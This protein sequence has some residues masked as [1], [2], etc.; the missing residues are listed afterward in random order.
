VGGDET[1]LRSS[2]PVP[3]E[4]AEPATGQERTAEPGEP[5]A[6]AAPPLAGRRAQRGGRR[7]P[8]DQD[9]GWGAPVDDSNDDRL[10]RERPPHW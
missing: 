5:T 9:V 1:V 3:A 6:D 7:A 4:P 10:N 8:D 2:F